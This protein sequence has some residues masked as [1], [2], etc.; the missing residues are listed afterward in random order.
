M[1]L[2]K[3]KYEHFTKIDTNVTLNNFEEYSLGGN[4]WVWYNFW[5]ARGS[6]IV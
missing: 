3:R 2:V 4:G 5:F 6:Y 1:K